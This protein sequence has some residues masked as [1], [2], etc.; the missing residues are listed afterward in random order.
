MASSRQLVEDVVQLMHVCMTSQFTVLWKMEDMMVRG[1]YSRQAE[2]RMGGGLRI[3]ESRE[4][5]VCLPALRAA[6][7]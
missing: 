5:E 4:V 1:D 6:I 2:Y 3:Y 7:A